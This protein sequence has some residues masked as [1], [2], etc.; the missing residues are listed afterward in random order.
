[1]GYKGLQIVLDTFG[2]T[3]IGKASDQAANQSNAVVDV[4]KQQAATI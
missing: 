1:L 3:V 2:I 4:P